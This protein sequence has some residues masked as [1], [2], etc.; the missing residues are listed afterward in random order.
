MLAKRIALSTSAPITDNLSLC[1]IEARK[2]VS[3]KLWKIWEREWKEAKVSAITRE[4]FPSPLDAHFL[5]NMPLNH[6]IAQITTGHSVL[7]AHLS[8]TNLIPS[9]SC[10]CGY[11]N[12]DVHHFI[13]SCPTFS[14]LRKIFLKDIEKLGF[15]DLCPLSVFTSSMNLWNGLMNF[16]KKTKRL[17]LKNPKCG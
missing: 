15:N 9:P 11:I 4:F 12:E 2:L 8:K 10:H 6:E 7:N 14:N 13:F 5:L 17:E 1:S 16:V 3:K